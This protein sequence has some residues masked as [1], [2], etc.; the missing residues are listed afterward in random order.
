MAP[1]IPAQTLDDKHKILVIADKLSLQKMLISTFIKM[2]I[3]VIAVKNVE[4][5]NDILGQENFDFDLFIIDLDSEQQQRF[6]FCETVRNKFSKLELP[7]LC[8]SANATSQIISN[9]FEMGVN[10]FMPL[11]F[12]IIEFSSKVRLMIKTKQLSDSKKYLQSLIDIRTQIFRVNTHDLKNPLSSIFSLSGMP[13]QS[14]SDMDEIGQTFDVIHKASKIMMSLV[15]ANLEFLNV[16]SS[17]ITVEKEEV[18]I[19][20]VVNQIVE[21]N[22]PLAKG[23]NQKI[24][25]NYPANECIIES[26][27]NKI[28]QAINNI[29]GNAIKFSQFGKRVWID[30]SK[31][32]IEDTV[33]IKIEDEGPGFKKNEVDTVLV[34]FGKL[35][36]TPTGNEISTGLGLLITKQ[37]INLLGG[38]I[39]LESEEG[40]GAKF[41]I[42]FKITEHVAFP[43]TIH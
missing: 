41:T 19:I 24:I 6:K 33:I 23:K 3:S 21:I 18:D 25:Y 8:L 22:N 4:E 1:Q 26:D 40:K 39:T 16:S 17:E 28:Y 37:I 13:V 20:S 35:S 27:A 9:S 38:E 36:A 7:L 2:D 32:P 31:D 11:P 29:V 12:N 5:A 10:E 34:K 14:F 15:N 43:K 30:V 42:K